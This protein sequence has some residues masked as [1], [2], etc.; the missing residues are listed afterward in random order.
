[1]KLSLNWIKDYV[2]IPADLELSRIAYDLTMSTVEVENIIDLGKKFEKII[3]GTI[4]EVLPHS[5]ADKLKICR[6]DIGDGDIRDIVCG[7]V[8]VKNN[9]KVA[10]ALPGALVKWHGE[11]E[12][13]EIKNA[14][15]RGVES[16]GMICASSEIGL[17]DLLPCKNDAEIS[18]LSDFS[19]SA[20][21]SLATALGL[22]DFILEIDNKSLTNRPDLWGH[23]GLA[24]EISALYNFPLKEIEE[25]KVPKVT[26][27]KVNIEQPSLCRRYI[28]LKIEGVSAKTSPFEVQS[29]LWRV[30]MRP[31]NALVDITNYVMLDVGQPTHAFDFDNLKGDITVRL[32]KNEKLLALNGKELSLSTKDLIIADNEGAIGLAGVIGGK[33]DSVFETT[34]KVVLEIANFDPITIRHTAVKYDC[35][36]ESSM[37]NEK[38]IDAERCDL[39]LSISMKLFSKVFP[40]M[41]ITAFCN[42]YSTKLSNNK[43]D[44]SYEWL[45]RRLGK[46]ISFK[47]VEQKL[48]LLGFKIKQENDIMHITVPSW[49]STGDVSISDDILEEVA[50]MYGLENFE[51]KSIG[52]TFNGA[53]NQPKIDIT[54]KIKEYLAFRC[55]FNEI[56]SYPWINEE[57][58][59]AVLGDSIGMLSLSTPPSPSEKF[60]RSS[61]L[62]NLCKVVSENL[63]YFNEFNIFESALVFFDKDYKVINDE[64]ELLPLQQ[65]NVAGA[66]VGE[67]ESVNELFRKAKGTLEALPRYTN[68]LPFNFERTEK[69]IWADNVV[70]LNI[71][72]NSQTIGNF[73]L[74]SRK[75]ALDC[76]IKNSSV[77]LFELNIEAI[78]LYPSRTN[79]FSHLAQYPMTERDLS[80]LFDLSIRWEDVEKVIKSNNATRELLKGLVFV[81]EY[82]GAQV[83]EN[84]KSLTFKLAIGSLNKTLT[85]NEIDNCTNKIVDS[86]KSKLGAQIR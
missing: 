16:Y 22:N 56:F 68:A 72:Q 71:I 46:D 62:P 84:K 70:W 36:T 12:L 7:G 82:R 20:G 75:I 49:R 38:G 43:I 24:R 55:N 11:G 44:V 73:G 32:A 33:K 41:K 17:S 50:R 31:I 47:T 14:K 3:V 79:K 66:F 81:G 69:P 77:V 8:N 27:L 78:Q 28:G 18:D 74:L 2:E 57:Y 86:L 15:V 30:G 6:T 9:M 23:Y 4:K 21:T 51:P 25:Y 26:E 80:L 19:A 53:I 42:N 54:R 65:L 85:S 48:E 35:R 63:R 5:N 37:R 64:K 67:M 39:A 1:M 58:L 45:I 13:V 52:T 76:G 83:P 40:Q 60:L 61:L 10:V 59:K 29:R 34:N